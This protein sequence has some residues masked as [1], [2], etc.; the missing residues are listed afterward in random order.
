MNVEYPDVTLND[1]LMTNASCLVLAW[2]AEPG[3]EFAVSTSR[4]LRT[5]IDLGVRI[6]EL[7]P[8]SYT[9]RL[10]TVIVTRGRAFFR[11]RER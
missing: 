9:A 6:E 5:W 8:G 1:G 7:S 11:V 10:P 3:R 2:T 4:D